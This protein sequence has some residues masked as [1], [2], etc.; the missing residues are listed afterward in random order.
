MSDQRDVM[1]EGTLAEARPDSANAENTRISLK[2]LKD[3][4][5]GRGGQYHEC[6]YCFCLIFSVLMTWAS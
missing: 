5:K 4:F 2:Q 1:N 6:W 3:L